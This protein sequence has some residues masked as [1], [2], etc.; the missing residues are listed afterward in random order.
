MDMP[1][2]LTDLTQRVQE[3][4]LRH[5]DGKSPLLLGYS[6]G[7][8]SKALL[9][10]LLECGVENLHLAHVD[11]GWRESSRQEAEELRRESERLNCPFHSIRL[12][13]PEK[14]NQ[15]DIARKER[16]RFFQ[17]L[18]SHFAFQALL[19]GHHADDLAETVLKRIFEGAH[20]PFLSGMEPISTHQSMAVWRP[21]LNVKKKEIFRFLDEKRLNPIVDPT[22]LDPVFLRARMRTEIFP[23]LNRTFG[24]EICENLILLSQRGGELKEYLDGKIQPALQK[25]S[26]GPWGLLIEMEG[27]ERIEKRHLLQK[28]AHSESVTLPRAILET[29]LNGL[30]DLVPNRRFKMGSKEIMIDRGILFFL[31]DRFPAPLEWVDWEL[32][33]GNFQAG[34]WQIEVSRSEEPIPAPHWKDVWKGSFAISLPKGTYSL[35]PISDIEPLRK[36]RVP[37]F[38][39]KQ[40]PAL[41]KEGKMMKEFLSGK[42]KRGGDEVFKISFSF[43][44]KYS[45]SSW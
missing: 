33:M 38:F 36:N 39:R 24:K 25:V 7:P 11:H 13:L 43:S 23:F 31:A 45:D 17:S 20:L 9:Y 32:K 8:D 19:L 10:A 40:M 4:L 35:L 21:L 37:S 18:F 42:T 3:F 6:G 14:G 1:N 30:E 28:V 34:D 26:Q 16:I 12:S 5:H 41:Y 29:L 2:T 15:E 44:S 22:N 27:L